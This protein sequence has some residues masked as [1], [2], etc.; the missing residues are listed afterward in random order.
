MLAEAYFRGREAGVEFLPDQRLYRSAPGQ[1]GVNATGFH[2]RDLPVEGDQAR[3]IVVLGDSMT[4]GQGE[5]A[6]AWPRALERELGASWQVLNFSRY[7]S[8]TRQQRA[9]LPEAWPYKPERVMVGVYWNDAIPNR[10]IEIG[11]PAGPIWLADRPAVWFTSALFRA[12]HGVW[13]AEGYMA[14]PEHGVV[15]EQLAGIRD[16]AAARGVPVTA[17]LLWPHTLARGVADCAKLT[18]RAKDCLLARDTTRWVHEEIART[19]I[20]VIDTLAALGQPDWPPQKPDD[21]EHP[22]P[23]ADLLIAR[24]IASQL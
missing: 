15:G 23:D 13:K 18:Q 11:S 9:T 14:L 16:D 3:R 2:E 10:M 21:W 17:V 12:A 7:G 20:P 19:G 8:D 1:R 4:W 6:E 22:G 24:F 5:A